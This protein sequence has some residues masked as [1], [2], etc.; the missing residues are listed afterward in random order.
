[1]RRSTNFRKVRVL[2]GGLLVIGGLAASAGPAH[3]D[4]EEICVGLE[5]SFASEAFSPPFLG[6]V[7][8]YAYAEGGVGAGGSVSTFAGYGVQGGASVY[9]SETGEYEAEACATFVSPRPRTVCVP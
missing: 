6:C 4:E 7:R 2:V 3:A 1:M 9:Q 5:D 8:V